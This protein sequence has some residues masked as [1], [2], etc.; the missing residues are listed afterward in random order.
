MLQA[1]SLTEVR[2]TCGTLF[3]PVLQGWCD[4]CIDPITYEYEYDLMIR[5][6]EFEE[7]LKE[8][9]DPWAEKAF[10]MIAFGVDNKAF[11]VLAQVNQLYTFMGLIYKK[12]MN[13]ASLD[14]G[15]AENTIAF[16]RD[17]YNIACIEANFDCY[18]I[19]IRPALSRFNL[20]LADDPI[21]WVALLADRCMW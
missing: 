21:D 20:L 16:Y 6:A 2:S 17:F 11:E 8:Y 18:G 10:S 3:S 4:D 12:R 1:F 7:E 9:I 13:D 5:Y 14:D 19:D 15:S